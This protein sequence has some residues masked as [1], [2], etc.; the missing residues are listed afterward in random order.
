MKLNIICKGCGR[1]KEIH[2]TTPAYTV[3]RLIGEIG[4]TPSGYES[5]VLCPKCAKDEGII[6][7]EDF[8]ADAETT[9][10]PEKD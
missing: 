1:T 6:E 10:Y 8:M 3:N 9:V 2:V 4:W 5:T 7:K